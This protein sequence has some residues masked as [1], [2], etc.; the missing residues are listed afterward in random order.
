[1][2]TRAFRTIMGCAAVGVVSLTTACSAHSA[3]AAAATSTG[4]GAGVSTVASAPVSAVTTASH[5]VTTATTV[6][7]STPAMTYGA[8]A[9]DLSKPGSDT[10]GLYLRS[11]SGSI[12]QIAANT[13]D[14]AVADISSNGKTVLTAR[15]SDNG[16]PGTVTVWTTATGKAV[17]V[18]TG[19]DSSFQAAKLTADGF[20]VLYKAGDVEHYDRAGH[21]LA[22]Y[23][24]EY[25]SSIV[26]SPDGL[27]LYQASTAGTRVRSLATGKV[28]A[29]LKNPAGESVCYPTRLLDSGHLAAT[30]S[31]DT[32]TASSTP[33]A[34]VLPTTGSGSATR[35]IHGANTGDPIKVDGG[36]VYTAD[37]SSMDAR[38][39]YQSASGTKVIGDKNAAVSGLGAHGRLAYYLVG[40]Q[41]GSGSTG[42]LVSQDLVTQK[43]TRIAGTGTSLPG[44]VTS[45][46]VVDGS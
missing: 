1:M 4:V 46:A 11:A 26:V 2:R 5:A 25:P 9:F 45:A 13:H 16:T 17:H 8:I 42:V 38:P 21:K 10:T 40:S 33:T 44:T 43:Q 31:K 28:T 19:T 34:Y 7:A 14:E 37:E 27:T 15:Y 3:P 12:R 18:K 24:G 39:Y 30:C 20:V 6:S 23:S 35:P 29:T 36:W 22:H 32:Q 41:D